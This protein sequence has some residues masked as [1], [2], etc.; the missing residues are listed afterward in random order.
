MLRERVDASTSSGTEWSLGRPST[1][2]LGLQMTVEDP[3]QEM[4]V[5]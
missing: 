1:E 4:S 5:L 3:K 2:M